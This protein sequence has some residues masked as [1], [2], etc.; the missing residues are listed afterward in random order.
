MLRWNRLNPFTPNG[1]VTYKYAYI[2]FGITWL[3]IS[4]LKW[5]N[6]G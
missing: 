3:E 1:L 2:T 5:F 6:P 4:G